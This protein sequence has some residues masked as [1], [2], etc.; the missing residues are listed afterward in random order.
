[1]SSLFQPYSNGPYDICNLCHVKIKK[2]SD[3]SACNVNRHL[4]LKHSNALVPSYK[5][6]QEEGVEE[7]QRPVLSTP[8]VD[9]LREFLE[10]FPSEKSTDRDSSQSISYKINQEEEK[11]DEEAVEESEDEEP[12]PY[13]LCV[14]NELRLLAGCS[15][16][17]QSTAV[18]R[19]PLQFIKDLHKIIKYLAC[20]TNLKFPSEYKKFLRYH[21]KFLSN[22]IDEKNCIKKKKALLWKIQG[23]FLGYLIQIIDEIVGPAISKLLHTPVIGCYPSNYVYDTSD[24]EEEDDEEQEEEEEM[25]CSSGEEDGM[26]VVSD[27][28]DEEE[29]EMECSSGEEDGMEVVSDEEDEEE[30]EM[31]CSSG[32]EDG[33]EV[34]SDEEDGQESDGGEFEIVGGMKRMLDTP[35]KRSEAKKR[36]FACRC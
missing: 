23:G 24:D 14:L 10:K 17:K 13:G 34:V 9:K 28:E 31:E 2:R 5:N 1:M 25:E 32:E 26:E 19:Y 6:N 29:E 33:M 15:P 21:K 35:F 36:V 16:D 22:F 4:R 30:E 27:E 11:E 8:N 20:N 7:A 18:K 3:G 12:Q